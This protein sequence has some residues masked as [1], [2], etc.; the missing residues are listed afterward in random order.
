M[1]YANMAQSHNDHI[2]NYRT[3]GVAKMKGTMYSSDF[4]RVQWILNQIPKDSYVLEVGC[5]AGT[6]ALQ[7]AQA[8][9]YVKGIDIVQE[10]VDKAVS[11]GITAEQGT[12]ED[13]SRFNDNEFDVVVCAEVLEHLYDPLV[14]IKEAHRVLK[15]GG[16]YLV[17]VPHPNS[18]M[19]GDKIG[20]Y[21]QQNFSMEILDTIFHCVFF[22]DYVKFSEIPY[23]EEFC[24]A[25]GLEVGHMGWL[26]L[27][28]VK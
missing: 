5:N 15:K 3:D 28:C 20:D 10:L 18:Q 9:C 4:Y 11:R 2:Q 12:A 26:A 27:E 24:R 1:R 7:I 17:T 14:A 6:V 8:G 23:K 21:H 16:K 19:A 25:N 13:L 22:R